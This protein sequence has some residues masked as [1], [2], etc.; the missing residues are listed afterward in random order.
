[1]TKQCSICGKPLSKETGKYKCRDGVL[2]RD[3]LY[4]RGIFP[5]DSGK[6]KELKKLTFESIGKITV[7]ETEKGIDF[8]SKIKNFDPTLE[9]GSYAKFDDRTGSMLL[10]GDFSTYPK[11]EDYAYIRYDQIAGYQMLTDKSHAESFNVGVKDPLYGETVPLEKVHLK[12]SLSG[13]IQIVVTLKNAG[14]SFHVITIRQS[15]GLA[16][17]S[18]LGYQFAVEQAKKIAGKL[19][20]ILDEEG[21]SKTENEDPVDE[22]RRYKE[23]LD[24]GIITI[25]EFQKKKRELLGF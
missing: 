16:R 21:S 19:Q 17:T 18:S 14:K 6:Q 13:Q 2:C 8:Y 4:E 12:R 3:C 25:A 15:G 20:L 7:K 24:E 9:V 1:M 23:L 5:L 10:L 11:A 22:I